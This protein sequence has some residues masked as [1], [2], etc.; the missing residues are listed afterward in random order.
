M[1]KQK[2][3]LSLTVY[4]LL[5]GL[6]LSFFT[7]FAVWYGL[8]NEKLVYVVTLAALFASLLTFFILPLFFRTIARISIQSKL[9]REGKIKELAKASS[10]PMVF[11]FIDTINF[12]SLHLQSSL[13]TLDQ[14]KN[15]TQAERQRIDL[16][17]S[18]IVDAVIAVDLNKNI[19][20]FNKAAENLTGYKF[21]QVIGHNIGTII[22]I[23]DKTGEIPI[24]KYCPDNPSQNDLVFQ[25][26]NVKFLSSLYTDPNN[27]IIKPEIFVNVYVGKINDGSSKNLGFILTF[28]DVS[29]ELKLQQMQLDFVSMAAHELRTPLTSIKGYLSVFLQENQN[30]LNDD[31]KMLLGRVSNS[32]YQLNALVENLLNVSRIERGTFTMNMEAVDWVQFVKE[33][34]ENF[35][36]RANEKG[37][38]IQFMQPSQNIPK[39]K[40]DKIRIIEVLNNLCSNAINYTPKGGEIKAWVELK[41]GMVITHIQDTGQGIPQEV[42]KHLFSKFYRVGGKLTQ[43]I[44]GT[45]LG[46]YISKEIM[47]Y[48]KGNIWVES[49]IGK[50][51]TFSFSLPVYQSYENPFK[52]LHLTA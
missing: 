12:L 41:E 34:V 27:G 49:A 23:F 48:H 52:D 39:V 6:A 16:I 37:I 42:L 4:V 2:I 22:K 1:F 46:L 36:E 25:A 28:H 30:K 21:S 29:K 38:K 14:A 31:Q 10:D 26:E 45:G 24:N 43:G 33:T 47:N 18:S 13:T 8:S 51:S 44:K 50:G 3:R 15:L 32:T 5:V 9:L 17:I 35:E 19:V 20:L 40:A 7:Y 11:E